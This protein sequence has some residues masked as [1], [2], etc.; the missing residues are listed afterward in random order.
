MSRSLLTLFPHSHHQVQK[1]LA[2]QN[3]AMTTAMTTMAQ[4]VAKL[5]AHVAALPHELRLVPTKKKFNKK[6]ILI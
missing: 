3:A 5:V 4:E 2:I 1:A 6:K